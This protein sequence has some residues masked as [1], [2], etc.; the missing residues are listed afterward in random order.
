MIDPET[1]AWLSPLLGLL[2]S[3]ALAVPFFADFLAKRRR[4]RHIRS[5]AVFRPED[6][7]ILRVPTERGELER[8]LAAEIRMAALAVLGCVLLLASF[9]VVMAEKQAS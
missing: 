4:I 8:V 5:L 1:V 3:L 2:G 7:T 9:L 6:A